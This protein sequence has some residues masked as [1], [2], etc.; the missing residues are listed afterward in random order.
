MA[1]AHLDLGQICQT[2][3]HKSF[4]FMGWQKELVA[5]K[6]TFEL[7]YGPARWAFKKSNV[8]PSRF[9]LIPTPPLFPKRPPINP[10]A[11]ADL[12]VP[13]EYIQISVRYNVAGYGRTLHEVSDVTIYIHCQINSHHSLL[14]Q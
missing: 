9:I 1:R 5:W 10:A 7:E 3:L 8:V 4:P 12:D 13:V 14:Y 6:N 11:T 2:V